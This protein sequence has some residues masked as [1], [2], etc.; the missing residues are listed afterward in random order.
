MEFHHQIVCI[1]NVLWID[2]VLLVV[3]CISIFSHK[4]FLLSQYSNYILLISLSV[5]I[6]IV[7]IVFSPFDFPIKTTVA[8]IWKTIC[9]LS[10]TSLK[11]NLNRKSCLHQ[12]EQTWIVIDYFFINIIYSNTKVLFIIL[13]ILY[14]FRAYI[15]IV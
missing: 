10:K 4:D 8:A 11:N 5:A 3:T 1:T 12:V 15:L 7:F 13:T 9:Y 6:H 14:S 2:L